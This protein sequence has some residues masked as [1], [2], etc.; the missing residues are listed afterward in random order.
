[1]PCNAFLAIARTR[2]VLRTLCLPAGLASLFV[3][4]FE[5]SGIPA[6]TVG[7]PVAPSNPSPANG[8]VGVSLTSTLTWTPSDGAASYDIYLGTSP[9]SLRAMINGSKHV[10]GPLN[11]GA[12][13]YWKVVARNS[14]GSKSSPTWSFTT[15]TSAQLSCDLNS[16]GTVNVVDVRIAENQALG[17][18]PCGSA[19]LNEDG[20]CNIVDVQ[21]VVDAVL[22]KGCRIGR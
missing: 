17:R 4:V 13:Y 16:D 22:G 2:R 7:L 1:M 12:K 6:A 14:F 18:A 9:L 19:D 20:V 3:L 8:A 15:V 5:Q 10:I 21:R 11:P